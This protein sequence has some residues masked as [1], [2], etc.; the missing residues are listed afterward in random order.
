MTVQSVQA[1]PLAGDW[2]PFDFQGVPLSTLIRNDELQSAMRGIS[3][4]RRTPSEGDVVLVESLDD[5]GAYARVDTVEGDSIPLGKGDRLLAVLGTRKSSTSISARL[6]EIIEAGCILGLVSKAGL[7]G[8]AT[9]TPA[10][11]KYPPLRLQVHG[12]VCNSTGEALNIAMYQHLQ[13]RHIPINLRD[14]VAFV[15]GTAAEVGK[16]TLLCGLIKALRARGS[17]ERIGAIK[18][19]GTGR[20]ADVHR[21]R[22][23]GAD[24]IVDFVDAG[25]PTT[26]NMTSLQYGQCLE[27]MLGK[28]LTDR[29]D[30][31]F[32]EIG[33]DLLDGHA[34]TALD[35]AATHG[36]ATHLV[37]GDAMAAQAALA[38]L[39]IHR[40]RLENVAVLNRNSSAIAERIGKSFVVD[41]ND[42]QALL[43]IPMPLSFR[44]GN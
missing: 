26:Y 13:A 39:S 8:Q 9:A 30:L 42:E 16:T 38:T 27:A 28:C 34:E 33:G 20:L 17:K 1:R 14:R 6:P 11:L 29:C 40:V 24:V 12:I 32:V 10:Y 43:R 4:R 7:V 31:I 37:V 41:L 25:W 2:A 36:C 19:C 18:A 21:Y 23:A 3:P 22:A 44:P 5:V 15:C 35:F